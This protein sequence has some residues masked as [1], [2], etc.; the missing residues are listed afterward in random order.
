M[1]SIVL[2][3]SAYEQF[4][5]IKRK[6]E[7]ALSNVEGAKRQHSWLDDDFKFKYLKTLPTLIVTDKQQSKVF[8]TEKSVSILKIDAVL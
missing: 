5:F 8:L 2:F 3:I 6:I 1:R 4:S 7:T